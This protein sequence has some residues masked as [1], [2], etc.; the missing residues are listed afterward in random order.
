MEI[1]RIRARLHD[2]DVRAAHVFQNLKIDL[3]IAE[4]SKPG[5]TRLGAQ[6]SANILGQARVG[7]ATEN[8]KLV[9]DQ[10]K[11]PWEPATL[12]RSGEIRPAHFT[13]VFC[14]RN[15]RADENLILRKCPSSSARPPWG[16]EYFKHTRTPTRHRGLSNPLSKQIPL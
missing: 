8:F 2:E 14:P 13:A 16:S 12:N 7:A 3:A 11:F 6:V 4:L 10:L 1:R 9:V 5:F 15:S